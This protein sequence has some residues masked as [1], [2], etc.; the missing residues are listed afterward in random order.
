M[1]HFNKK[2]V[3]EHGGKKGHFGENS[4]K[5]QKSSK[6]FCLLGTFALILWLEVC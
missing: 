6:N 2:P 4:L 3:V 1:V 5:K